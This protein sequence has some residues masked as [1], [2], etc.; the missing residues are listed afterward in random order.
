M[1][2]DGAAPCPTGAVTVDTAMARPL[3]ISQNPPRDLWGG[4]SSVLGRDN[5]HKEAEPAKKSEEVSKVLP[6]LRLT[7]VFLTNNAF[8]KVMPKSLL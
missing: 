3:N 4:D 6:N 1:E 5:L 8:V 2:W 7:S